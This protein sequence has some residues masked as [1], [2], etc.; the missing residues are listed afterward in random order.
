MEFINCKD[1]QCW[2]QDHWAVTKK[3]EGEKPKNDNFGVC[4][5]HAPSIYGINQGRSQTGYYLILFKKTFPLGFFSFNEKI[6]V[7]PYMRYDEGCWEG[8][9]KDG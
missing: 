9:K 5:R 6:R 7:T 1:C 3:A 8:I 4:Q 2:S